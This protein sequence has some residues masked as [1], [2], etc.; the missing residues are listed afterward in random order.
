[1]QKR[2]LQVPSAR[3]FLSAAFIA[4]PAITFY[5]ILFR[6]A[7]R[8]PF[9]D[10]YTALLDF[11]NHL[12][13]LIGVSAKFTYFLASQHNE[14]KLFFAHAVIWLQFLLIGHINLQY[15]CAIGDGFVLLLAVLLWKMFLPGHRDS[16]TR[17]TLFAPVS[18]FLFQLQYEETLNWAM[19]SLQNL[20][21]LVFS[22][23]G[24][25]MLFRSSQNAFLGSLCFMILAIAASG[26]GFLLVPIGIFILYR[27]RR[28]AQALTWFTISAA[29]ALA[30]AYHYNTMSSQSPESRSVFATLTHLR[31]TY[32]LAFIGNVGGYTLKY[33]GA[34]RAWI[35][36]AS[37]CVFFAFLAQRGY[38]RRN[39]IVGYCVL[40]LLLTAIGVAG[41]RS[42][43]GLAQS[44]SS[45]YAIYSDLLMI[46][47]W[48]AFVEEFMQ[49]SSKLPRQSWIL[50][51][52]LALSIF[53]C[54]TMD[55]LGLSGLKRRNGQLVQ[56]M[57]LFEH[58]TAPAS[59]AGP[60]PTVLS[61]SSIGQVEALK[62]RQILI[63]AKELGIYT[64]PDL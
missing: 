19:A 58:P 38:F 64:P 24:I 3:V 48:T 29:C 13:L 53:F 6:Q 27:E 15:L 20:P 10:D 12:T 61:L 35:T 45:R 16:A 30:Y 21:V 42:D 39:P 51:G 36:G 31:W 5:S 55:V 14:Y 11:L 52:A 44:L 4:A 33:G 28:Y 2:Q 43:F 54:M 25:F 8:L 34:F 59:I 49:N 37:L 47:A 46:F 17:L 22:L 18:Y 57:T 32:T 50:A 41:L 56:G 7:S 1:V 63:R 60:L 26:N 40:F 23:S 62:E 9:Y